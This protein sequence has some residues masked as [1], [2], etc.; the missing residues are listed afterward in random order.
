MAHA[1]VNQDTYSK[2]SPSTRRQ[3]QPWELPEAYAISNSGIV[4]STVSFFMHVLGGN[5][6]ELEEYRE[7][8]WMNPSDRDLMAE[9]KGLGYHTICGSEWPYSYEK[10]AW[11][12][13]STYS[14]WCKTAF[15]DYVDTNRDKPQDYDVNRLLTAVERLISLE[16][17][18]CVVL[19]VHD[20]HMPF[21]SAGVT[22]WFPWLE[23]LNDLLHDRDIL[24]LPQYFG[25]QGGR[26][27]DY[28]QHADFKK[29]LERARTLQIQA[30]EYTLSA[31]QDFIDRHPDVVFHLIGDHPVILD[32]LDDWFGNPSGFFDEQE[33]REL[34]R[35]MWL[36]NQSVA[37]R[38][39]YEVA[40]FI[41]ILDWEKNYDR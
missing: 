16:T 7:N 32:E 8:C 21:R 27:S 24:S 12:K 9:L 30:L 4:L 31:C 37:A 10:T 41:D 35:T 28:P 17:P 5:P 20:T 18:W 25:E 36:T 11:K 22:G 13:A 29:L 3:W 38:A 34:L 26:W 14:A 39:A 40:D 15:D 33:H 6:P 23:E 1:S 2:V 19:Q